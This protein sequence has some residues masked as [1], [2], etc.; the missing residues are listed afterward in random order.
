LTVNLLDISV[1]IALLDR[2]HAAHARAEQWV[3]SH[4][5]QRWATCPITENGYVR[6][7]S[8]PSYPNPISVALAVSTLQGAAAT[9][10]HEFWPCDVSISDSAAF[11][12][13]AILGSSQV[14]D[15]YLLAL[16]ARH[17]G[18]LVTLDRQVGTAAVPDAGADNL[19]VI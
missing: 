12:G 13:A 17:G 4:L 1:L 18:R 14:T 11:A 15:V 3:A 16:A 19:V 6:I 9:P 5:E 2:D 8:Q 10:H 7:V